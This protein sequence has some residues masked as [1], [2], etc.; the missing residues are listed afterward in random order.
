MAEMVAETAEDLMVALVL[1]AQPILVV[2]QVVLLRVALL[3]L[4]M[5]PQVVLA[6][7]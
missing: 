7:H 2:A 5:A 4:M 6:T 1:L 3:Q